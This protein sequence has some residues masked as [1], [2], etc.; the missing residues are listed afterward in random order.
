MSP[1]YS[2][3]L[4]GGQGLVPSRSRAPLVPRSSLASAAARA[5]NIPF[6]VPPS[7]RTSRRQRAVVVSHPLARP[8]TRLQT[9]AATGH[10]GRSRCA[11]R[12]PAPAALPRQR[13]C[14][15]MGAD[16]AAPRGRRARR[17]RRYES[18]RASVFVRIAFQYL[19]SRGPLLP[20]PR[21][22]RRARSPKPAAPPC[23]YYGC[24]PA[25][26]RPL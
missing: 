22:A 13:R 8:G 10:A 16:P 15:G 14:P 20:P 7:L 19:V 1:I 3:D 25:A 5:A 17:A 12:R 23:F 4:L 26:H 11:W 2:A 21:G 18:E 24:Q 9:G 6:G